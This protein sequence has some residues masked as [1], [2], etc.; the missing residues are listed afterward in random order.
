MWIYAKTSKGI[1]GINIKLSIGDYVHIKDAGCQYCSYTTAFQYFWGDILPR[2]NLHDFDLSRRN[3]H[4]IDKNDKIWKIINM[5]VHGSD[6]N[7]VICHIRNRKGDNAV[8]GIDGLELANFHKRNREPI[9]SFLIYQ[10]PFI[11]DSMPHDWHDKLWDF[12]D[13]E[14]MKEIKR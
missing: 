6:W 11:G 4:D 1:I 3:L 7:K 10:L 9:K 12:Y 8:I 14:T 5:V 13:N 2:R